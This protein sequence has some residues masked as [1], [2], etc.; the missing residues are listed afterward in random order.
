MSGT[1]FRQRFTRDFTILS[2]HGIAKKFN[3]ERVAHQGDHLSRVYFI[4]SVL[5]FSC[6][7][8][9]LSPP[10][11]FSFSRHTVTAISDN[12]TLDGSNR[13]QCYLLSDCN[14]SKTTTTSTYSMLDNEQRTSIGFRYVNCFPCKFA[15]LITSLSYFV[16][17]A[18]MKEREGERESAIDRHQSSRWQIRNIKSLTVILEMISQHLQIKS[19]DTLRRFWYWFW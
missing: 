12:A 17:L 8:L 3:H 4:I 11:L 14:R 18:K 2:T 9:S 19:G 5:L 10:P 7:S 16:I 15:N 13:I 6:L 1:V